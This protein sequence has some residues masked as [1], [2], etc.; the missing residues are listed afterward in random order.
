MNEKSAWLLRALCV[1]GFIDIETVEYKQCVG[2]L[3][4]SEYEGGG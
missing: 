1:N 2:N 4:H 3:T